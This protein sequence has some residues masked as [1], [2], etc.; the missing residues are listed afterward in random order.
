VFV[1]GNLNIAAVQ[2]GDIQD[3][4]LVWQC[5]IANS[6][7]G[8]SVKGSK[9]KIVPSA[10]PTGDCAISWVQKTAKFVVTQSGKFL[11]SRLENSEIWRKILLLRG[12]L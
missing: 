9:K 6:I 4:P 7:I 5:A 11:P 12:D 1:A 2:A 3:P 10:E 8:V